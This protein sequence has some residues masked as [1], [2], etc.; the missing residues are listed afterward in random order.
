MVQRFIR[1]AVASNAPRLIELGLYSP[2][3][4]TTDGVECLERNNRVEA[5]MRETLMHI[6]I[7]C[8]AVK[9]IAAKRHVPDSQVERDIECLALLGFIAP[10]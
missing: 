10:L 4:G 9:E 5:S 6:S 2:V 3:R 1:S 7:G 8:G